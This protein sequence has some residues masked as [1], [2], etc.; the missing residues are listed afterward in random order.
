MIDY[1]LLA[2]ADGIN[3]GT[4]K[5]T[6]DGTFTISQISKQ[7]EITPRTLR[8]LEQIGILERKLAEITQA[9][10]DLRRIYTTYIDQ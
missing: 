10:A 6:D 3:S 1:K 7:F 4:A 2:A 9:L 8:F 5:N